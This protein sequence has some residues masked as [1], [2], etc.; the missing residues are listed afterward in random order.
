MFGGAWRTVNRCRRQLK[1][2]PAMVRFAAAL[3]PL[4]LSTSCVSSTAHQG[5]RAIGT[6]TLKADHAISNLEQRKGLRL[7]TIADTLGVVVLSNTYEKDHFISIYNE[8]G[9]LWHQFSFYDDGK[10]E[11]PKSDF[12]P[13][14]F[15]PDYFL[16]VMTCV[17]KMQDR[18]KVIVNEETKVT[19]F[20]KAEDSTLRFET[21]EKHVLDTFNINFDQ[22]SNPIRHA[23]NGKPLDPILFSPQGPVSGIEVEGDWLKIKWAKDLE[24]PNADDSYQTGWISWKKNGKLLIELNYLC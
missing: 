15:H 7:I 17:E 4:L 10:G 24:T 11:K 3:L 20:V 16:L 22:K 1:A 12:R 13:L 14:A 2:G 19:K 8:D 23:P 5:F 6:R 9:S 21:W 18:L